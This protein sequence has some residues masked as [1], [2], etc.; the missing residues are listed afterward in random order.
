M[1]DVVGGLAGACLIG[2]IVVFCI[3]AI[4][5]GLFVATLPKKD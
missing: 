2:G 4:I 1:A 3:C 5:G